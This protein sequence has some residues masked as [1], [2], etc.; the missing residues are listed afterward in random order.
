M[1]ESVTASYLTLAGAQHGQRP[2]WDM[3]TRAHAA[4]DAGISS[5]GVH[6]R[7]DVNPDVL[8][9]VT[10]PELEW[11]DINHRMS[12]EQWEHIREFRDVL[13]CTR[14]NVGV[15]DYAPATTSRVVGQLAELAN[16]GLTVAFEPVA[17]GS[18]RSIAQVLYYTRHLLDPRVG[19]LL[20]M[21]HVYQSESRDDSV[22][23]YAKDI[24]EVQVCGVRRGGRAMFSASQDRP[25]ITESDVSVTMWLKQLRKAGC[26]APL[27]YENPRLT[28]R[29]PVLA[30]RIAADD[31]SMLRET[32]ALT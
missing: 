21:W 29:T 9:L 27:S 4:A 13:G 19:L 11:V 2:R 5:I 1:H 25:L 16:M 6:L 15:C 28:S 30:A 7:E 14:I 8:K 31:I 10:V 24:T 20:D 3:L 32:G 22:A 26:T 17:F 18:V 23:R 12:A